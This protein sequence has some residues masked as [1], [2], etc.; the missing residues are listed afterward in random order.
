MTSGAKGELRILR[1]AP[2]STTQGSETVRVSAETTARNSRFIALL[3]PISSL[4][5]IRS[6][7]DEIRQ[8]HPAAAHVVHAAVVGRSSN[9]LQFAAGDDGEPKGT[10]GRPSLEVLKGSGLTNV[11]LAIVRYFGGTKL[12][13]GGLVRAYSDAARAVLAIAPTEPLIEK[14]TL[15]LEVGYEVYDAARKVIDDAGASVTGEQFGTD[16]RIELTCAA[17]RLGGLVEEFREVSRGAVKIEVDDE[18]DERL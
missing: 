14:R 11:L 13:T 5:D 9:S 12:G 8:E 16:V 4:Q 2:G 3:M 7:I 10:S 15:W 1:I 6:H 17:D 18:C